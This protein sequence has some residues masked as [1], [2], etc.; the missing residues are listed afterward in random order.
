MTRMFKTITRTWNPVKG[1]EHACVYCWARNLAETKLKDTPRYSDGFKPGLIEKELAKKFKPGEF[2]FVTD[3]GDLY[4]AW[5]PREWIL[6]VIEVEKSFPLTN[7]LNQTKNPIR[8]KEFDFPPHAYL[9][10]TIETN[11]DYHLTKAPPPIERYKAIAQSNH[12]HKFISIEPIC[13]FDLDKLLK[14][15]REISPEIIEVGADNHRNNLPEPPWWKVK[16]LLI[17]LRLVCPKVVEK[18]GLERLKYK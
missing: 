6:R 13:D 10:T 8:F 9:G 4:G 18:T 1:C 3:M 16:A 7:F 5:V 17:G 2:I 11:R 15:M 12:I 14:W